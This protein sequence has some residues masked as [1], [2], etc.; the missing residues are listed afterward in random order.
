MLVKAKLQNLRISA[1]KVRLVADLIRLKKLAKAKAILQFTV[2]RASRD[3]LKLLNQAEANAKNNLHLDPAN[4]FVAEILVNEGRKLKRWRPRARGQAYEI[5]KKTS[6]IIIT[7]DEI[8]KTDQKIEKEASTTKKTV[9]PVEPKEIK[10]AVSEGE[11][12][13]EKT[14]KTARDKFKPEIEIK[15]PKMGG[16]IKKLFQ[17]KV[18]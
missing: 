15:K 16:K 3:L 1:R 14:V 7:L 13:E 4:L 18:Y 5:Q 8:K 2:K 11:P 12:K 10:P 9:L 17:R 6:H